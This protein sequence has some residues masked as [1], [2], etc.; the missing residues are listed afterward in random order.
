MSLSSFVSSLCI[1]AALASSVAAGTAEARNRKS[2]PV[3]TKRLAIRGKA[4]GTGTLRKDSIRM[5]NPVGVAA[6]AT[7]TASASAPRNV[8]AKQ[9][10][11]LERAIMKVNMFVVG[12]VYGTIKLAL[13]TSPLLIAMSSLPA[14]VDKP[15][16]YGAFGLLYFIVTGKIELSIA[17]DATKKSVS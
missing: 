4:I 3:L 1:I 10:T 9:L 8:A 7:R 11:S 13:L 14:S 12:G 6:H 15:L 16:L 17:A 5:R 2:T